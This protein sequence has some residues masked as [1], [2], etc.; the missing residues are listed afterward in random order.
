METKTILGISPGT[1][2]LGFAVMRNQVLIDYGVKVYKGKISKDKMHHIIDSVER[3][4]QKYQPEVAVLKMA[5]DLITSKN[6]QKLYEQ[7]AT[8]FCDR[9][10]AFEE[11]TLEEIKDTFHVG[12]SN[13]QELHEKIMECYPL[14]SFVRN[15]GP[16]RHQYYGKMLEAAGSIKAARNML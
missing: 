13:I 1:Y 9:K 12:T 11:C 16:N 3:L 4:T 15:K 2:N 10:I 7:V 14:L 6:M 8:M 5:D